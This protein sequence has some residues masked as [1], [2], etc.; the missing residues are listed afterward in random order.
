LSCNSQRACSQ[1][2]S[3]SMTPVGPFHLVAGKSSWVSF[4]FFAQRTKFRG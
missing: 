4:C 3:V 1:R 2:V